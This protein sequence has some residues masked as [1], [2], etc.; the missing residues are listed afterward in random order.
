MKPTQPRLPLDTFISEGNVRSVDKKS[1]D[2]KDLKSNIKLL[3]MD[4]PVTYRINKDGQNVI[5]NGHQRLAI[6][7]DLGYSDVPA[8][9]VNGINDDITRQVSVNTFH[10]PMT[11]FQTSRAIAK[12]MD[13][14]P[15]ITRSSLQG[16][17]G[18][19][20]QW[21]GFAISLTNLHPAIIK[22]CKQSNVLD[23]DFRKLESIV[24]ISLNRQADALQKL[25]EEESIEWKGN[26]TD[27][28]VV[29]N[30]YYEF[31]T[32]V[33]DI[34]TYAGMRDHNF[35]IVKEHIGLKKFREYEEKAGVVH[36]YAHSLFSDYAKDQWYDDPDF[37]VEVFQL[38][39]ETGEKYFADLP[40]NKD[41]QHRYASN[42]AVLTPDI[43]KSKQKFF[44]ALRSKTEQPI[45]KVDLLEWSGNVFRPHLKFNINTVTKTI[46][47]K[48]VEVK[49]DY[50]PLKNIYNKVNKFILSDVLDMLKA[51]ET[52]AIDNDG[53]N[54]V[55]RWLVEDTTCTP[56]FRKPHSWDFDAKDEQDFHPL[57]HFMD[58]DN[59]VYDN[60]CL[61]NDMANFWLDE[62]T[63]RVTYRQLNKLF[64]KMKM[65]TIQE[66]VH[67]KYL[68]SEEYR[69]D[70]L[71]LFSLKALKI[72]CNKGSSKE[73]V[74]AS[75]IGNNDPLPYMEALC[76]ISGQNSLGKLKEYRPKPSL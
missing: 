58:E 50:D 5:I 43:W 69:R 35:E 75:I 42:I 26:T 3:G 10:V 64:T 48:D 61:I 60:N 37:L 31:D 33:D 1:T 76:V 44:S 8:Y 14:E 9:E 57:S 45:S 47:G 19:S 20:S 17:F 49:N 62:Y 29:A 15:D 32:F 63:Y 11:L 65:L 74:I 21:I 66:Y 71:S 68:E 55:L 51:V 40:V 54:I 53:M 23:S 28:S 22:L 4:T 41:L 16:R 30:N 36:Q 13:T 18:K 39:T 38:E 59:N 25:C 2:Y 24:H 70:Y 34:H 73:E 52:D 56:S 27:L 7:K 72:V 46:N 6:A 12:M 67:D